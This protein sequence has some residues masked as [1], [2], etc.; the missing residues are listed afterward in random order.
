MQPFVAEPSLPRPEAI[1]LQ[2]V[3]C[4]RLFISSPDACLSM[5]SFRTVQVQSGKHHEEAWTLWY[6]DFSAKAA[7]YALTLD[8]ESYRSWFKK[9]EVGFTE[10]PDL[11]RHR[12]RAL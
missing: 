10:N 12:H 2:L 9:H 5:F 1:Y 4:S 8:P 6:A 7:H 3:S 11:I